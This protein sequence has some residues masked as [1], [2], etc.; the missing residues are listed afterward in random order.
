MKFV[1]RSHKGTYGY[2]KS[3]TIFEI[4]KTL[5]LY[6]MALGLYFIGYLTLHTNKSLWSVLAVLAILPA[7]KSLVGVIMFLRYKSLTSEQHRKYIEAAGDL[8]CLFE[9][10]LTTS[11]KSYYVPVFVCED[12]TLIGY[13]CN[14]K[15]GDI[16][17]LT[18]HI[19]NVLKNEGLKTVSVKIFDNEDSFLRRAK[20][21]SINLA[22]EN[23][24][25]TQ[26]I[27]NTIKA[28]SL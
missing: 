3:Q 28:V 12:N 4:I 24:S 8:A 7:S 16:K 9:N 14:S 15:N 10:V 22:G 23:K 27:Y 18:E 1:M 11:Q 5:I 6:A 2:L 20:E 21:M 17:A 25:S 13:L 19:V 26:S